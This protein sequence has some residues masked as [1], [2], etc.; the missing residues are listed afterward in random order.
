[1]TVGM[2]PFVHKNR[3]KLF[4]KIVKTDVNFPPW[5]SEQCKHLISQLLVA[6]PEN[7]MGCRKGGIEELKN[8]EWFKDCDFM[9]I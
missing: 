1:M 7:R 9:Q 6:K 2:P 8:H 3:E 4:Q 5:L